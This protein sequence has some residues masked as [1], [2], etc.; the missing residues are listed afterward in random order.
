MIDPV[1]KPANRYLN[2]ANRNKIQ[3]NFSFTHLI[4]MVV[5][6]S[7]SISTHFWSC[8][9]ASERMPLLH[10]GNAYNGARLNVRHTSTTPRSP[11]VIKYS[12]SRDNIIHC[13]GDK[14]R[15]RKSKMRKIPWQMHTFLRTQ[16]AKWRF[17]PAKCHCATPPSIACH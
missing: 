13:N 8:V 9:R 11:A 12:P 17:Q 16:G 14:M 10:T 4:T 1:D 3:F 6:W 7:S 5:V 15:V 2:E